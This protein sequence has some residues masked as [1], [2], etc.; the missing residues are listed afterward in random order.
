LRRR[1]PQMRPRRWVEGHR[2][3]GS[4]GVL[5]LTPRATEMTEQDWNFPEGRF[6]SYVLGPVDE[7]AEALFVVLNG[8]AQTIEFKFPE[9]A[10]FNR[11]SFV[12]DTSPKPRSGE[13]LSGSMLDALPR[14]IVVFAGTS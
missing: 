14:S 9:L 6:L 4:F 5:W 12:L 1:F 10:G 11:W 2:R 13:F 7:S 3:D 8:A